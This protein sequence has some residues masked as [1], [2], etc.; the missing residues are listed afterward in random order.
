M[1]F[2]HDVVPVLKKG[3]IPCHGGRE[4]KGSFSMNT[5]E[6]LIDSGHVVAGKPDESHL[7]TLVGSTDEEQQMPPANLARLSSEEQE[8]LRKWNADGHQWDDGFSFAP[9]SYEPPLKPRRPELPTAI[10]GRTNPIDRILD[11]EL[12]A[13]QVPRPLPISDAAF[14]RRVSLDLVG[15][16]PE[17][18]VLQ[19]FLEDT[20]PDKRTRVIKELLSDNTAYAS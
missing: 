17:P 19:N 20:S 18:E 9:I 11:A 1:D 5:R 4:A 8:T 3:C 7:L 10:D 12:L 16:L 13:N 15:L 14:L 2:A 6:L